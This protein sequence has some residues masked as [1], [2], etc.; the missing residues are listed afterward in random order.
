MVLARF[1]R[2]VLVLFGCSS[3]SLVITGATFGVFVDVADRS[4]SRVGAVIIIAV[5]GVALPVMVNSCR[6]GS[7]RTSSN[8]TTARFFFLFSF[9]RVLSRCFLPLLPDFRWRRV[10]V[11]VSAGEDV[12][13][14]ATAVGGGGGSLDLPVDSWPFSA[15]IWA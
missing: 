12:W 3:S 13:L 8:T 6:G 15:S 4:I 2:F 7:F 1:L 11:T 9:F 14:V 10:D 5:P